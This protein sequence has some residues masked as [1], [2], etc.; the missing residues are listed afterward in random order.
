LIQSPM[1]GFHLKAIGEVLCFRKIL[2]LD[3]GFSKRR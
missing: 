1:E 3:Q 2:H